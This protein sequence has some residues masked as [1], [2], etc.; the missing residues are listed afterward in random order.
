MAD[1]ARGKALALV[2]EK[3]KVSDAS[4][5]DVELERLQ[6]DGTVGEPESTVAGSPA[7]SVPT[8][9]EFAEFDESESSDD[10]AVEADDTADGNDAAATNGATEDEPESK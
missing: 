9:F 3:A 10:D 5:N 6:E 7:A 4:G 1:V 8:G 2:V